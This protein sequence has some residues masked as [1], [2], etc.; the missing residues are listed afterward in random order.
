MWVAEYQRKE[1]QKFLVQSGLVLLMSITYG[2]RETQEFMERSKQWKSKW[3]VRK[4]VKFRMMFKGN[5][6]E[7]NYLL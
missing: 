6:S 3:R 5:H 4:D 7:E 2:L 1:P